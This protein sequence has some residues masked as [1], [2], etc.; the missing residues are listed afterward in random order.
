MVVG[1]RSGT[2]RMNGERT[3]VKGLIKRADRR[4][5]VDFTMYC[6]YSHGNNERPGPAV[7]TEKG[8]VESL[9]G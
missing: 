8:I 9:M 7:R 6:S 3:V 5:F 4:L 1:S 2:D